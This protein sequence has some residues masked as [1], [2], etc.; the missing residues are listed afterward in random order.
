M[1]TAL[2]IPRQWL[3]DSY[4]ST[5]ISGRITAEAAAITGLSQG[6]PV[7]GGGGDQAAGAVGN[8]IINEGSAS[9]SLGTS[10]VVFWPVDTPSF[11]NHGMLHSFCH[12]VPNKWHLMGVT[13]SAGGSLKWFRDTL[14]QD[15]KAEASARRLDPYEIIDAQAAG[16]PA[17]SEGLLF[18]PYLSGERTPH[19]DTAARGAFIGLSLRHNRAHMARAVMEGVTMSLKDCIGLASACGISAHNML[20]SGGGGRSDLWRQIAADIFNME[21]R[22]I[23]VDE[24]PAY[25]AAIIAAT[26]AGMFSTIGEACAKLIQVTEYRKPD[27]VALSIYDR[28]YELYRPLYETLKPFFRKDYEF[29]GK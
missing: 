12:A 2:D 20:L 18:L 8:G 26:G 13:L 19:A 11:D 27:P 29:V 7:V 3:P 9:C 1:L 25:G 10:G 23:N 17:G 14:C 21:I 15:I 24:G 4:E 22:R 28:L 5:E 6:I 16:I